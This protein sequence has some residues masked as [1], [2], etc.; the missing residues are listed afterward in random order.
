MGFLG[1]KSVGF[2]CMVVMSALFSFAA[3]AHSVTG[4]IHDVNITA[5]K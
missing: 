5:D 3:F 1:K 2:L 4:K